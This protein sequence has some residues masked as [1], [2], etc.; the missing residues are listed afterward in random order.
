M[1]GDG[2]NQLVSAR[3]GT[4]SA[5]ERQLKQLVVTRPEQIPAIEKEWYSLWQRTGLRVPQ[6]HPKRFMATATA[7]DSDKDPYVVL[8]SD[9]Q[10]PRGLIAGW[11]I[12][13]RPDCRIGYLRLPMPAHRLLETVYGGV[14]AD[15]SEACDA[16]SEHFVRALGDGVFESISIKYLPLKESAGVTLLASELSKLRP[17]V[18]TKLHWRSD[19]I[20]PTTG[21]PVQLVSSKS[22][23]TMRRKEKKLLAEFG[24]DVDFALVTSRSQIV[25]FLHA[26]EC[27]ESQTYH[28]ALGAGLRDTAVWRAIVET[29]ASSADL[30]S[31]VLFV[32]GQPIAYIFGH[33][34]SDVWFLETT[35][36]AP[37]FRQFS[38]GTIL[39]WH[40]LN[41]LALQG[42]KSVDFGLGDASYKRMYGK[43]SWEEATIDVF[44][45]G[46]RALISRHVART[47]AAMSSVARKTLVSLGLHDRLK[48]Y[49]RRRLEQRELGR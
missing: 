37:A 6:A 46:A 11:S 33:V 29:T 16:I 20:D 26:A 30:R 9:G 49:W 5:S 15:S 12:W 47:A 19:L 2:N 18:S 40:T 36:Y 8:F 43:E 13:S 39:L 27:I 17:V 7:M 21:T 42:I 35:G 3:R 44:G 28:A 34:Y 14:I 22:R 1:I 24:D 4:R 38:P 10:G 31:Y 41:D 32:R 45:H 23:N 48:Q 25:R